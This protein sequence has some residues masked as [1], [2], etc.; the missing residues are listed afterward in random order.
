MSGEQAGLR[1]LVVGASSG[2]GHA[3]ATSAAS[4]GA[5]VAVAA[6]R[7][8]LLNEL[9]TAIGGF[10]FEL[11]VADSASIG[12]VVDAAA[13]ALGGLDAVVFTSTVIPFAHIEDTDVV[14][15]VHAFSVNTVGANNVLRAA[16]PHLSEDGVVLVASNNDVGRPRAGVAAY[17]A[18]KAAL[19]EILLAWRNEH[20]ELSIVRVGIGPTQDTEILR[21]ADRELLS[22]LMKSW[23][24]HGQL[25][26][27]MSQLQD[28]ANTLVSL[29]MAAVANPSVVPEVVQLAPRIRRGVKRP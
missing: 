8:D 12:P 15:W 9:A 21:G 25:P 16:L 19:D 1:L 2:I 4:Q 14:T 3:V 27:Q 7:M 28:V 17:G 18:S 22:Q 29:V 10:A 5:K 24:E 26:E 23:V 6:R 20:P 11:D 13:E